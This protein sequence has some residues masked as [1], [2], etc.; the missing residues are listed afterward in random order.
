MAW[1]F[2]QPVSTS[3][4]SMWR[5]YVE[6]FP[7]SH[8]LSSPI[9]QRL[10]GFSCQGPSAA[11]RALD[12]QYGTPPPTPLQ[13]LPSPG[14]SST[15]EFVALCACGGTPTAIGQGPAASTRAR[16]RHQALSN[17]RPAF[18]PPKVLTRVEGIQVGSIASQHPF[19]GRRA[20]ALRVRLL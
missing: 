6:L 18:Q 7:H 4:S 20:L 13:P 17:P 12:G 3:Y 16:V 19:A 2:A 9:Q 11:T 1:Q 8:H 5:T 15:G 14:S 10:P